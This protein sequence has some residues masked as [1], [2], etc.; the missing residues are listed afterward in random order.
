MR[1]LP[2]LG[3]GLV[4]EVGGASVVAVCPRWFCKTGTVSL[5]AASWEHRIRSLAGVALRGGVQ[6]W[7]RR[8]GSHGQ[9]C[10]RTLNPGPTEAGI[11]SSGSG[12]KP[13]ETPGGPPGLLGQRNLQS[14]APRPPLP[15]SR[16]VA[17]VRASPRVPPRF[18]LSCLRN[19][20]RRICREQRTRSA[21]SRPGGTLASDSEREA[22]PRGGVTTNPP[23]SEEDRRGPSPSRGAG[24][25][26]P[27]S[28]RR[29]LRSPGC[30]AS[31]QGPR[32]PDAGTLPSP[33]PAAAGLLRRVSG[34]NIFHYLPSPFN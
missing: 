33:P 29:P 32:A 18:V 21:G 2:S 9:E 12:S 26:P 11:R 23:N 10:V 5:L 13:R 16:S 14:R 27:S 1:S 7:E 8:C 30:R 28:L 31:G 4:D 19:P 22:Q 15:P 34:G 17:E 24:T 3:A 20:R 25:L 6:N